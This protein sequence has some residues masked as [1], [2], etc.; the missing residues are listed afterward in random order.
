MTST[1]QTELYEDIDSDTPLCE[2]PFRHQFYA[3][4]EQ[5]EDDAI[6]M[7]W[8]WGWGWRQGSYN[9]VGF[10]VIIV[11]EFTIIMNMDV[12]NVLYV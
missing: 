10:E 2:V 1:A 8:G 9:I 7:G 4:S 6:G 11:Q 5:S 3:F 12:I